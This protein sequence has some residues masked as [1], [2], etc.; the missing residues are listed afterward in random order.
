MH[1]VAATATATA[2]RGRQRA[3]EWGQGPQEVEDRATADS[4][5]GPPA[6]LLIPWC[7]PACSPATGR[8]GQIKHSSSRSVLA[9][10]LV[11][12][13][14][15]NGQIRCQSRTVVAL[16]RKRGKALEEKGL[17]K[18]TRGAEMNS[19]STVS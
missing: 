13:L 19:A 8:L 11:G 2:S 14:F 12:T 17:L 6:T 9:R 1:A 7:Y 3:W 10:G 15:G 4:T 5:P 18:H 16:W